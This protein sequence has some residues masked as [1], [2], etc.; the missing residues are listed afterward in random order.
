[1]SEEMHL[2]PSE[3]T[4]DELAADPILRFFHYAHLPAPLQRPAVVFCALAKLIVE[5]LPRNAERS[6]AL[7]K[8]LEAKDCAV[9]AESLRQ[10]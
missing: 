10:A 2:S 6:A 4:A 8:L 9:R 7:R 1:M 3:F 5:R